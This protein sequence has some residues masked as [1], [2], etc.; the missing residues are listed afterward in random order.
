[1]GRSTIKEI[2]FFKVP[3]DNSYRNV[4]T[5]P[6]GK[7]A[8]WQI[9]MEFVKYFP[10]TVWNISVSHP[11]VLKET[12]GKI[13][14]SAT[15]NVIDIKDYNY[16]SIK[17]HKISQNGEV[18]Y[19]KF[20]FITGYSSMNQGIN[21]TTELS[22]EYDC[23]LN[24]LN[25]IINIYRYKD[26]ISTRGHV[27]DIIK[28][29]DG[30]VYSKNL[31]FSANKLSY[32][33]S[34][35][36][37][38]SQNKILWARILLSDDYAYINKDGTYEKEYI[39]SCT[40]IGAQLP[41]VYAPIAVYNLNSKEWYSAKFYTLTIIGE[42]SATTTVLELG[43]F[44][45]E[46]NKSGLINT[47]DFTF[48][49]PFNCYEDSTEKQLNFTIEYSQNIVSKKYYSQN[50]TETEPFYEPLLRTFSTTYRETPVLTARDY[51]ISPTNIYNEIEVDLPFITTNEYNAGESIIERQYP[52]YYYDV[53]IS[54][55]R[56]QLVIP[57]NAVK[58]NVVIKTYSLSVVW[59]VVYYDID[60]NE[61]SQTHEQPIYNNGLVPIVTDNETLFYRN[62]GNQFKAQ[63]DIA[64]TKYMAKSLTNSIN[65]KVSAGTAIAG[66]YSGNATQSAKGM[67]A[68]KENMTDKIN[69]AVLLY[70][71][72]KNHQATLLDIE[73][74][75]N[76]I[77]ISSAN[78]VESI[79]FQNCVIINRYIAINN[80]EKK[81]L[82]YEFYRY[83]LPIN[84]IDKITAL[85]HKIFNYKQAIDFEISAIKNADERAVVINILNSGVTIWN[86]MTDVD[87][88]AERD[89]KYSMI[90]NNIPNPCI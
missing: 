25:D 8:G 86:F 32:N 52:F 17:Y 21:P 50:T 7:Q 78:S 34:S 70:E 83:G 4:Y 1:M 41:Y 66:I 71:T 5:F 13:I 64:S 2:T 63:Q 82:S 31:A 19:W 14:L 11:V 53:E 15:Y 72:N 38:G 59:Y 75:L 46:F 85:P 28:S 57:E 74:L 6:S 68:L 65:Q 80:I 54:G 67:V 16:C 20:Y 9:N 12:N 84:H 55:E 24:N 43:A 51:N 58:F 18:D 26:F 36:F 27:E 45:V 87:T 90:A 76:N 69:N 60:G 61:I 79:F 88:F 89:A 77:S 3:F 29:L 39:K 33:F 30:K 47:V 49:P 40:P 73:N 48:Y 37:H 81:L 22:L 42:T 62:Q 23:W 10:N 44:N 56:Y 35:S